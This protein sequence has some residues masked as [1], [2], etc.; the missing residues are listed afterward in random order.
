M[1]RYSIDAYVLDTLMPDLVGH[2]HKPAAFVVFLCLLAASER[3]NS[4]SVAL[5]LQEISVRTGLA[6]ST[7]QTAIRHLKRR[8]LLDGDV[9]ATTAEPIRRIATPWVR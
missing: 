1:K 3:R 5:S 6:K 9:A 4:A 8:G 7:V 2:D